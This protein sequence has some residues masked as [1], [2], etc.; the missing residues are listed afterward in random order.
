MTMKKTRK[1][2]AP[3][4]NKKLDGSGRGGGAP[5]KTKFEGKGVP[6]TFL[7]LI[8]VGT[9]LVFFFFG[10]FFFCPKRLSNGGG[11]PKV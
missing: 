9:K 11:G 10:F 8:A 7:I 5:Q 4:P 2:P 1:T 6:G 3:P